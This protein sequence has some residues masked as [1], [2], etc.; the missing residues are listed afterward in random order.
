MINNRCVDDPQTD[1]F[2]VSQFGSE[3]S[4]EPELIG[5]LKQCRKEATGNRP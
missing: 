5:G 1:L 2:A 4:S 3:E